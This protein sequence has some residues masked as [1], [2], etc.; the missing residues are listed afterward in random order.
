M[1]EYSHNPLIFADSANQGNHL[2]GLPTRQDRALMALLESPSIAAA[3]RQAEV[4]ESTLRQWLRKDEDFQAMLRLIRHETLSHVT[5]RLQQEAEK[6]LDKASKMLA[7]NKRIEPGRA[8]LIRTLLDFAYR[9]NAHSDI[10]GVVRSLEKAIKT[11]AESQNRQ[12][13]N[14]ASLQSAQGIARESAPESGQ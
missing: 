12:D 2:N 4:G 13:Q 11:Q 14:Q 9:S 6:A 8:S 3:A 5:T 1:S 7:A 10:A